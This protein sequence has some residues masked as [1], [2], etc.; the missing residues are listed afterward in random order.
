[1]EVMNSFCETVKSVMKY[2]EFFLGC[3]QAVRLK[4]MEK[5]IVWRVYDKI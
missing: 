2:W 5:N 1:M 4:T 3:L